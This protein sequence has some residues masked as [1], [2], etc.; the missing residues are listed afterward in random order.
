MNDN[1][2]TSL[3]IVFYQCSV[4]RKVH[5]EENLFTAEWGQI[6]VLGNDEIGDSNQIQK[7]QLGIGLV[8]GNDAVCKRGQILSLKRISFD[9]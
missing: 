3:V 8:R 6:G 9:R 1:T 4:A 2:K 5:L 7:C